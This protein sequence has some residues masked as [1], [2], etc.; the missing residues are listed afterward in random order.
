MTDTLLVLPGP[1]ALSTFRIDKLL[2]SLRADSPPLGALYAEYVHLLIVDRPLTAAEVGRAKELL[3]YGPKDGLPA[4]SGQRLCTVVPRLGT[5]SPWSSKA[6]DIFRWCGLE[7]VRR[8]ERGVRWYVDG[9]LPEAGYVRLYDRMTQSLLR[10]EDFSSLIADV[11]PRP[12][13]TVPLASGGRGALAAANVELGLALS[14]DEID[15]LDAA[16]R[17]LGRDPTDIELM[18]FAQANS[19][20]CRHKIFNARWTIDGA[21]APHSLFEMIRN[22]HRHING[23]GILSAYSDNAAVIEGYRSDR[24]LV[25][26]DTKQYRFVNE[27]VHVLMKVET[28]NHPTA[29]APY[30]GA[31]TGSGGEIRDEG[32]VGRGSKPKAGLVGFTTSHLEIPDDPQPWELGTGKPER[33][34]SALDIMLEGPIGG[35]TFNNEFGRPALAGYFRTFEYLPDP[36]DPT[37]VRGYH[38]PVMIAG[39]LGNVRAEHVDKLPFP[40]GT[41]LVV[42]GGPAMLIGLGGGAA[43]SMASG[44]SSTDLDFASVQRDNA[45]MERRCQEVIDACATLGAQN[46]IRLI[47]D[48]GAGGLSNALPELV[49]DAGMGG[50]FEL[51]RVP[52]AD[53]AMSPLEIWCNEAQERYVLAID[54]A[55]LA[56][57]ES[58]CTRERCPYAVVGEATAEARIEVNDA[59]FGN[60]PVNLPL[61]VLFGR[62]PRMERSFVRTRI[63]TRPLTLAGIEIREALLEVLRFPSV[64]SKKFLVTIGDRSITGYVARD[65]MVGPWQVPVADVAVT[66]QGHRTFSGEAMAMGERPPLALLDPAAAARVAVGEALLNLAAVRIEDLSRVVLSANWM[67]AAG[68]GQEDQALFDAVSAVG[69]E[70]CPALGIAIP[71]GKDSLSM[72]T[73]WQDGGVSRTVAAPV[74]LNVTAFAPVPDVRRHATPELALDQGASRLLLLDLGGGRNRLGGSAFAQCRRQLGDRS[75]DLDDPARFA[76]AFRVLQALHDDRLL[77]AYHDRSDGGLWTTVLE[78]AFAGRCGITLDLTALG[79]V[80]GD[81]ALAALLAEEL[82]AVLQVRAASVDSVRSRFAAA[83]LDRMV[84]D[85]GAPLAG[86][87]VVITAGDRTLFE[88]SRVELESR[89]ARTSYLLQRLRDHPACADE[90]HAAIAA[91]DPGMQVRLTFDPAAAPP[92]RRATSARPRVAILREQGV[93]GQIEMA[94]AFERAGFDALDVHMSDLL[95]GRVGL[96]AFQALA[97]CGGFSYG[98]VLGAGGGWAKSILWSTR[99]RDEFSAFFARDTLS[100]GVCNGCQMFSGIRTLVPGAG[101]WPRF[102]RNRSEQFE[103]R[104]V[105]VRINES[106]SPWLDGMAGSVL[107]VAVAHGEGR[108]ECEDAAALE[109]LLDSGTVAAQFVDHAHAPTVSYPLN[110][111]GSVAGITG[112]TSRDGRALILMPHP[113][114]VVRSV[115]NSWY[116][117]D[118]GDDGPWLRLFRNAHAALA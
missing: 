8:V 27:P 77:L 45:E 89:W 25:D 50:R 46:P 59:A 100:L 63:P 51:R 81:G 57:F 116:P 54:R 105:L 106:R 29:I 103:A 87:R 30:P 65:Q 43:S 58:I 38:K 26:P 82:G 97:A 31:A 88:E 91:D 49:K 4:R 60:R 67:A 117:K 55:G 3:T 17:E 33:I 19:E 113:E 74:T 56:R 9:A 16:Y 114:R 94:A 68:H 75:P 22:T 36:D 95:S 15:Y 64:G 61:A 118:W 92:Q 62:P 47:H 107:P 93:N 108:V 2:A 66:L 73:E 41:A 98:D 40:A 11:E 79:V 18:M 102:V 78:M 76:A 96:G 5:I 23:A 7:V 80:D 72:R 52:N 53:P 70:L 6:T 14:E 44:Q 104:S 109:H 115:S 39:G 101:H 34:V 111:N 12:L 85:V 28:H 99:A 110:P 84:H 48:V 71:V 83:G 37:Q 90:E 35:A 20:H 13:A 10:E 1:P 32:A 42:L 86:N 21:R 24:L 69:L 112:I